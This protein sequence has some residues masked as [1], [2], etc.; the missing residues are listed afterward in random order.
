MSLTL[1]LAVTAAVAASMGYLAARRGDEDEDDDARESA[2]PA[3]AAKKGEGRASSKP[4]PFEGLPLA[5]GDVVATGHEERWLAGALVL[6][7]DEHVVAALFLAPEG[8]KLSAV[9]VFAP[10]RRHIYWMDPAHLVSPDEPPATIELDGLALRR[11][12]R[13]PV[14]VERL[15][16]GAP[17]VGDEAIWATFEGGSR[18]VAVV[19]TSRGQAFAWKGRQLDE[20]EYDRLG[21]G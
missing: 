2:P 13:I 16:Q 8:A 9:A 20:G 5:L 15:G 19:M 7:E 4:D 10:P 3:A 17:S 21:A 18:D 14:T 6:R 1:I 12:G 11:K